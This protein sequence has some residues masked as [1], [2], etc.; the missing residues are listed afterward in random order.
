MDQLK[1]IELGIARLSYWIDSFENLADEPMLRLGFRVGKIAEEYGEVWEALIG[2]SGQNPRKGYFK[3]WADV[4]K[5]LLD[6]VVAAWGALE[7]RHGNK[8]VVGDMVVE[9][10]RGLLCRAGLV[11]PD[12]GGEAASA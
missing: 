3:S 10:V 6:T 5:E 8:A 4:D 7:H 9:H 2:V 11:R 12:E 1:E